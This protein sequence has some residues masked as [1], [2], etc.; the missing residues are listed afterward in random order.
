[1]AGSVADARPD[2]ADRV[3]EIG[4]ATGEHTVRLARLA[5]EVVGIDYAPAA[6]ARARERVSREP[7][8]NVG[9]E[10]AD[11]T[12]LS[13]WKDQSFDKVAAIDF[14]EH[15]DDEQLEIILSEAARVLVPAAGSPSTR[16]ARRTTSSG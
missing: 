11:A 3:L 10:V 2:T 15:V 7:V 8:G 14:V 12:D 16:P 6:I 9:F 13:Q 5:K 4:C 1:M